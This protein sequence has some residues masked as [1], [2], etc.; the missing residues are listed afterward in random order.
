MAHL[1]IPQSLKTEH[2]AHPLDMPVGAS[3]AEALADLGARHA[4]AIAPF[5]REGALQP[6]FFIVHNQRVL[7]TATLFDT[8]LAQGDQ[9][10]IVQPL[11]G[12]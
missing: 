11:S 8:R 1:F 7:D 10:R 5:W 6:G 12:G 9:V 2:L 3:V 4:G